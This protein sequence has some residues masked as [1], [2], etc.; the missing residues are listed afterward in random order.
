MM[1]RRKRSLKNIVSCATVYNIRLI[2]E[3]RVIMEEFQTI[4][5]RVEVAAVLRKA[6]LA[7]EYASGWEL[8]LTDLAEA[9]DVSRTPVREAFQ[10]LESEGLIT[11][12][13]NKGAIVNT[14]DQKFIT[15][16]YE[17]RM[18]L[19]GE[20][21]YRAAIHRM[22]V[23]ELLEEC[24]KFRHRLLREDS[25][26]YTDLN[27]RI[28]TAIWTAAGNHKLY[29][30]LMNL[31][32]GPSIGRD[33][34][35]VDHQFLSN[36]EHIAVLDYIRHGDAEMARKVMSRHIERS[37]ENIL[38]GYREDNRAFL[39]DKAATSASEEGS[40]VHTAHRQQV[41]QYIEEHLCLDTLCAQGV[42]DYFHI[43]VSSLSREMKKATGMGFLDYVH[44]K[45]IS[46]AKE[47]LTS[48]NRSVQETARQVGYANSLSLTRAFRRIEGIT[49]GTYRNQQKL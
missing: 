10:Q 32:N 46:L 39:V 19:E 21:A 4:P 44:T 49:P 12:R 5:K 33:T 48:E 43:S 8:S 35:T 34:N 42:A 14:I 13:M 17:M 2:Q 31:W 25:D 28:H 18:L 38:N 16:H 3:G 24:Q 23:T 15:D 9:L 40:R 41:L 45:R 20:A 37:M 22:N 30:T 1:V 27:Q 29:N 47:L 11:L 7:G 36:T 6:I 26:G